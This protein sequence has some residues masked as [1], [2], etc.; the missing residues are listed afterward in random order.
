LQACWAFLG[1][2][3]QEVVEESRWLGS[4]HATLNAMFLALAP[5]ACPFE[6]LEAFRPIS[7]CR[8]LFKIISMVI[9]D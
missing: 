7:L 8:M 2:E 3:I 4:F 6:I 5:K 1:K 9:V